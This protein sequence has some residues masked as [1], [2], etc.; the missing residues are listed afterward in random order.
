MAFIV[1]TLDY[2][3]CYITEG[4]DRYCAYALSTNPKKR[5]TFKTKKSALRALKTMYEYKN[6]HKLRVPHNDA[7]WYIEEEQG[8][9]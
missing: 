4:T 6:N 5:I 7:G 2:G 9:I 3:K 8:N 1:T